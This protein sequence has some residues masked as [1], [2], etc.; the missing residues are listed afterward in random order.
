MNTIELRISRKELQELMQA[1]ITKDDFLDTL[2]KKLIFGEKR[3]YPFTIMYYPARYE[4]VE[5]VSATLQ[6]GNTPDIE[7]KSPQQEWL[8]RAK[9]DIDTN[10]KHMN[11][12]PIFTTPDTEWKD[13]LDTLLTDSELPIKELEYRT[14]RGNLETLIS[15]LLSSRDTYWKGTNQVFVNN[16]I[17]DI[18]N[19]KGVYSAQDAITKALEIIKRHTIR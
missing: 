4:D 6:V 14:L 7:E 5:M 8:D 2:L 19:M 13:E 3:T 12:Q 15:S 10:L 1:D 9:D 16:I 11:N 18:E 17:E